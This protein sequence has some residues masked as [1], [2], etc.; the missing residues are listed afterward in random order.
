MLFLTSLMYRQ[1]FHKLL[2]FDCVWDPKS[3]MKS[4]L[5]FKKKNNGGFGELSDVGVIE[6]SLYQDGQNRWFSFFFKN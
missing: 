1:H 6:F 4:E 2:E 5:L 3:L